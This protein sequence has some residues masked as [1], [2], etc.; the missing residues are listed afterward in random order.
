MVCDWTDYDGRMK[1]L[2]GIIQKQLERHDMD[3]AVHALHSLVYP[4]SHEQRKGIAII[5]AERCVQKVFS[6]NSN[7]K[8]TN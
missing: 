2:V 7:L 3:L 8:I 6:H 1:R 4:I 5:H